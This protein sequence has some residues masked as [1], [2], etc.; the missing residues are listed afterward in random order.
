MDADPAPAP[1]PVDYD[2]DDDTGDGAHLR[3]HGANKKHEKIKISCYI[4]NDEVCKEFAE[5][6]KRK[7]D[8]K[9]AKRC[10]GEDIDRE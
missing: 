9:Y 6:A 10:I 3:S 2:D 4:C 8:K 5:A 1:E 7:R